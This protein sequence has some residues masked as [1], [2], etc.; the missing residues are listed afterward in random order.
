MP[1]IA[2]APACRSRSPAQVE[3][4][5]RNGARSCGPSKPEGKA[6]ASRNAL[7]HGLCAVRHLVLED[8]M[9]DDLEALIAGIAADTGAAGEVAGLLARRLAIASW[10]GEWAERVEVAL[11]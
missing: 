8:E 5:R 6:R 2:A 3:A 9:P 10:Q 4:S 11:L 1:A 7:T